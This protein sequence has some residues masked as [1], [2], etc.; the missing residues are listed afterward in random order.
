VRRSWRRDLD[1]LEPVGSGHRDLDDAELIEA[2]TAISTTQE[3][4]EGKQHRDLD[5]TELV[6]ADL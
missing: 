2:G 6:E 4:A 1:R 3:P 5:D